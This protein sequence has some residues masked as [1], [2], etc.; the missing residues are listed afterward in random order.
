MRS[1]KDLL[2][3]EITACRQWPFYGDPHIMFCVK[4]APPGVVC[5]V[6]PGVSPKL[7]LAA[8]RG[9]VLNSRYKFLIKVFYKEINALLCKGL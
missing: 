1:C 3:L 9:L 8:G 2:L 7:S 6:S 4:I 5:T